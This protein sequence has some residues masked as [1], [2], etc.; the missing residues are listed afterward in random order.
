M[1]NSLILGLILIGFLLGGFF[2]V[3]QRE[4]GMVSFSDN[5]PIQSYPPGLHWKVPF[6]GELSYVY[7]N[8]RSSYVAMNQSLSVESGQAFTSK[9]VVNWQVTQAESYLHY[10]N[11]NSVKVFDSELSQAVL[12]KLST[13]AVNAK[14]NLDFQGNVEQLKNWSLT[15]L[16]IKIINLQVVSLNPIAVPVISPHGKLNNINNSNLL[17]P[18]SSYIAAQQIKTQ[19]DATHRTE[20][21][22]LRAS[23]PQFFD[24]FIKVHNLGESAQSKQD[25]PALNKLYN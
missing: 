9:V 23:D 25:I 14:S 12:T 20:L 7:T 10:L 5:K 19:A 13:L 18:E 22:N 3:D 21:A 1:R 6:Y 24:Y 16:G 4:L 11:N 8:Q 2:S 17:S 15:N